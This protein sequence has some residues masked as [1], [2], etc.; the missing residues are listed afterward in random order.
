MG[1]D[2]DEMFHAVIQASERCKG[3]AKALR[4]QSARVNQM[5]ARAAESGTPID[6]REVKLHDK[7]T[8]A[9]EDATDR[10]ADLLKEF[11]G[12]C[13]EQSQ[14]L[15]HGRQEDEQGVQLGQGPQDG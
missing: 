9:W 12:I 10:H 8:V 1:A 3:L 15:G 5:Y 4:D 6:N 14:Q 7:L 11:F 13:K 2:L